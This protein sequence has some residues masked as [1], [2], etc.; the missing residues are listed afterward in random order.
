[1]DHKQ[2]LFV[3]L[4]ATCECPKNLQCG[5]GTSTEVTFISSSR[6][7]TEAHAL[8]SWMKLTHCVKLGEKVEDIRQT[9]RCLGNSLSRWMVSTCITFSCKIDNCK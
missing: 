2:Y 8:F 5:C 7:K 3:H 9:I 1:M 4:C 6:L